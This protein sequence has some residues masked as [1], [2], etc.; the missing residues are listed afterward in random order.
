M[1]DPARSKTLG[2]SSEATIIMPIKPGVVP[3]ERRT[4]RVRLEHALESIDRRARSGIETPIPLLKTIHFARWHIYD[5]APQGDPLLV[6]T[7]SF[8][9]RLKH[10]FRRFSHGIPDDVDRIFGN[11]EGYPEK[12]ARD[13]DALWRFVKRHQVEAK[14]FYSA[15]PHLT[16]TDIKN[17]ELFKKD[18]DAWVA[19]NLSGATE[20]AL[21]TSLTD[22]VLASRRA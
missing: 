13:F 9:G 14:T 17:L 4:Y 10:Y 8:D 21:K 15:F 3:G 6:F 22:F 7:V 11:C 16:L 2:L 1:A 20:S 18:F 12:G 5:P 19:A